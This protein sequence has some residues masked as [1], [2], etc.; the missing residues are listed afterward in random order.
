VTSPLLQHYILHYRKF[1]AFYHFTRTSCCTAGLWL[2]LVA[3][4]LTLLA[5]LTSLLSRTVL[6]LYLLTLLAGIEFMNYSPDVAV[7]T[8]RAVASRARQNVWL[9]PAAIMCVQSTATDAL[10]M[11]TTARQ[12]GT[13]H[14]SRNAWRAVRLYSDTSRFNLPS[15]R[16]LIERLCRAITWRMSRVKGQCTLMMLMMMLAII[17]CS[18]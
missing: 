14:A 4:A 18:C 16:W 1:E 12:C 9:S 7:V 6:Q 13:W 5:L 10:S 2:G 11:R 17:Y 8:L 15:L 3:L